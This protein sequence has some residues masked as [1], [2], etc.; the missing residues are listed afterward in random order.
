MMK[1]HTAVLMLTFFGLLFISL[2]D[3]VFYTSRLENKYLYLLK[4]FTAK[5][6]IAESFKKTCNGDGFSNLEEW[7]GSCKVLFKLENINWNFVESSDK[8]IK[9]FYASWTGSQD[10]P[11]CSAQV[12]YLN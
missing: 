4:S 1:L 5:R 6:F 11:D 3:Y 12:Y 8:S 9:L 10:S 7:Q 2:N